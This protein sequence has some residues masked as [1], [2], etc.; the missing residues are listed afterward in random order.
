[1]DGDEREDLVLVARE[2]FDLAVDGPE[3][4]A[5]REWHAPTLP[6]PSMRLALLEH[7][8]GVAK[9]GNHDANRMLGTGRAPERAPGGHRN[10]PSAIRLIAPRR[11]SHSAPIASRARAV[12]PRRDPIA[13]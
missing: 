13:R 6:V 7:A 9:D 4:D 12:S 8:V 11:R 2:G 3:Q 10:Y 5:E 1:M